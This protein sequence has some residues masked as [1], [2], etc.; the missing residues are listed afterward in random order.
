MN[1]DFDFLA[2]VCDRTLSRYRAM[3]QRNLGAS[4][5]L[6]GAPVDGRELA[7]TRRDWVDEFERAHLI[8]RLSTKLRAR[9]ED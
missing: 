4:C 8:C 9:H 6:P 2:L 7:Q 3:A 1:E 5:P